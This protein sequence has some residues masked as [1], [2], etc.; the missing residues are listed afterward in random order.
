MLFLMRDEFFRYTLFHAEGS[1]R[2]SFNYNLMCQV[3][4]PI[5]SLDIQK[6]ITAIFNAYTARRNI[7]ERIKAQARAMCPVL[8]QGTV[9]EE[10]IR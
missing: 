8:V 9:E 10:K 5:P 1:V 3:E 2:D 7:A 6:D 4:I